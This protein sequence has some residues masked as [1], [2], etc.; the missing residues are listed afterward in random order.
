MF[1]L[2]FLK[3]ASERALR[4]FCQTAGGFLL[5]GLAIN[6]VNWG[7]CLS[8]SSVA[9]LASVLMSYATGLP[10]ADKDVNIEEGE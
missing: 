2:S 7:M 1:T 3:A 4:T 5:T 6:E 10:E 8:V 9:A